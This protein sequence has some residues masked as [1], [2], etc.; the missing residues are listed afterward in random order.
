[1]SLSSM[2]KSVANRLTDINLVGFS[3]T[4]LGLKLN[5]WG[6]PCGY[7]GNIK[8]LWEFFLFV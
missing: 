1:M 7:L 8:E 6:D 2:N 4:C 3:C 5:K